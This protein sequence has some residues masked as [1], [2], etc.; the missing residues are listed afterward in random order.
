MTGRVEIASVDE[1]LTRGADHLDDEDRAALH[2]ELE[3]SVAEAKSGP[4]VDAEEVLA[5]L[6]A[7]R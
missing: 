4:L 3:G 7:G 1:V 2:R 6:R 5:E